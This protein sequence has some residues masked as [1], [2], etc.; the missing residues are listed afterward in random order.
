MV[1]FVDSKVR[2][3]SVRIYA[4]GEHIRP[5]QLLAG[6]M[7]Q[8]LVYTCEGTTGITNIDENTPG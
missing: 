2:V 6:S 1:D 3:V 4:C 8:E 5:I 7:K